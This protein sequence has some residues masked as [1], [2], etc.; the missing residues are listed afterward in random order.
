MT[1]DDFA[2]EHVD[3]VG[4]VKKWDLEASLSL[5][6][7]LLMCPGMHAYTYTLE[8]LIHAICINSAGSVRPDRTNIAQILDGLF[9]FLMER[10]ELPRDVFVVNVMTEAGNRRFLTGTWKRLNSGSN[11]Q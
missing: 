4:T 9:E 10:D 1:V 6:A 5:C 3:L 11:T 8:I 7:G 2:S